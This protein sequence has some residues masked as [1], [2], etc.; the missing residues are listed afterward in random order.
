MSKEIELKAHVDDY[1]KVL[2]AL[3]SNQ[4]TY[5]EKSSEKLDVYFF[6]PIKNLSFRVRQQVNIDSKGKII[7]NTVY[8]TK[9]KIIN[10]GIEQNI[11][12]EVELPYGEFSSSLVFFN[13]LGFKESHRKKKKGF[14]FLFNK[15]EN[16]LHIELLE[17]NNL[18]WFFEIEFIVDEEINEIES[19]KLVSELYKTL[20]LFN[21]PV[22]NIEKRYYSQM[23]LE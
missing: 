14:S 8:T 22:S 17:V 21:I 6:N 12:N 5:N 23:I 10:E 1:K 18:G 15:F 4:F 20:E 3:K 7:K 9:D 16:D 2:N 19:K 11:E 13:Q